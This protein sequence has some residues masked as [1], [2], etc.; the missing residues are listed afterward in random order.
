MSISSYDT[1][2]VSPN[3][4]APTRPH[5]EH[6]ATSLVKIS[7]MNKQAAVC[8]QDDALEHVLQFFSLPYTLCLPPAFL[9]E[10]DELECFSTT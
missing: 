2:D 8:Y 10:V 9:V 1:G 6:P 7:Q 3:K 4:N 5:Y